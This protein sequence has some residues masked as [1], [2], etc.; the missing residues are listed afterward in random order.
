LV[1]V[2][3][4]LAKPGCFASLIIGFGFFFFAICPPPILCKKFRGNDCPRA[5]T[6]SGVGQAPALFTTDAIKALTNRRFTAAVIDSPVRFE[7]P[8]TNRCVSGFL[9]F[10]LIK[11]GIL[12]QQA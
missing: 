1:R 11:A 6:I 3:D 4:F 2:A 12:A 9:M 5:G 7:S 8:W 10:S